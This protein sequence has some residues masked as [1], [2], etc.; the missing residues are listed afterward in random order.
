MACVLLGLTSLAAA[1][2]P[3]PRQ[4]QAQVKPAFRISPMVHRFEA[5]R[6][7]LLS[8]EFQVE[9]LQRPT[10]LRIRPVALRQQENGVIMPLEDAPAPDVVRLLTPSA[11]ELDPSEKFVI[12]GRIQ[13]PR[14][15]SAFHSYGVLVKD[16]GRPVSDRAYREPGKPRVGINFVTQYLLRCDISVIGTTNDE[17]RRLQITA[18]EIV[19]VA[20]RPQARVWV[21]NP[22]DSF[23]EFGVRCRIAAPESQSR[24]KPFPLILP[25]RERLEGPERYVARILPGSRVRLQ[26][27][28]P[29]PIF[30]GAYDLE[31]ELHS[32]GR[33]QLEARFPIVVGS[34]DFPAQRVE[35][36]PLTSEVSVQPAQI[37]LSLRQRG[38]RYLA[39]T[40]VNDSPEDVE[41]RLDA[42]DRGGS[43]AEWLLVRPAAF[44]LS[45]RSSRKALV[46]IGPAR[47]FPG[48]CYGRLNVSLQLAN[49]DRKQQS[50]PVALLGRGT[51]EPKLSAGRLMWQAEGPR[52][53]FVVDVVNQGNVHLPLHGN[54]LLTSERGQSVELLA[55]FGR[56]L[57]PGQSDQL[58]FRLPRPLPPGTYRCRGA[59]DLGEGRDPL[60]LDEAFYVQAATE[61]TTAEEGHGGE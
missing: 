58:T 45:S 7:K 30:P 44:T 57:L 33:R 51:D 26:E 9:S 17:V 16:L 12:R 49:G 18:G 48:N 22:T 60:T 43:A 28:L 40:L 11:V 15:K 41:V 21:S 8:F 46:L 42:Q 53:G 27:F 56:W 1:Q 29:E 35:V 52:Q 25:V 34:D 39:V 14:T 59:L 5:P 50:V 37:E 38:R 23:L 2:V 24:R 47:D 13:V 19:D 4:V 3:L 54:L 61:A 36:L 10:S 6:G 55:G 32:Q 20:G 31:I